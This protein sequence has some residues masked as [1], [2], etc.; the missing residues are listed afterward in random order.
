MISSRPRLSN[1]H[2]SSPAKS[3]PPNDP[4]QPPK[5]P[6]RKTAPRWLHTLWLAGLIVTLFLLF[7]PAPKSSTTSLTY[8]DWINKVNA[9]GVKTAVIDQT[10]KVTGKLS[11][12]GDYQS[13]IPTALID[14]T[15]A[16]DLAQH[17]VTVSGKTTGSSFWSLIGTLLPFI[18]LVALYFWISRR[19]TRQIAG[20]MMG[21]GA[22]K[23]KVYD[24]QRPTTRF[25]D[26]AGYEGAKREISEVVDFLKHADRYAR[27]GAVAPRGVLMVGSAGYGQDAARA[28]GRR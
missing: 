25:E 23:A 14:N 12:K 3:G 22:S 19:A 11:P 20:G 18:V 15:L 16:A 7:L 2:F 4:P 26:V 8:T 24:Q 5:T 1:V 9:G 13:R 17:K 10:G 27:A 21:I 6:P 28:S